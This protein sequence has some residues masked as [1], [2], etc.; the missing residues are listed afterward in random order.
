MEERALERLIVTT[1]RLA[2]RPEGIKVDKR[3][4]EYIEKY[5]KP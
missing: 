1:K 2:N 4:S 5:E 3:L